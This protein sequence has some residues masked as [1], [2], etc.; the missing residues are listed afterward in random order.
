MIETVI[1]AAVAVLAIAA[2]FVRTRPVQRKEI[3]ALIARVQAFE[4]MA[5]KVE[6]HLAEDQLP[7]M[8]KLVRQLVR[9]MNALKPQKALFENWDVLVGQFED[10]KRV[11]EKVQLKHLGQ[12]LTGQ[13]SA[14]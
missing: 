8:Y 10:L 11:V 2:A 13:G 12:K 3:D 1:W 4:A 7:A 5:A 6:P 14:E 9:D